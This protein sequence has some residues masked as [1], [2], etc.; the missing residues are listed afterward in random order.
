LEAP[1]AL[2]AAKMR[3]FFDSVGLSFRLLFSKGNSSKTY[4]EQINQLA[5]DQYGHL[6][7]IT[8]PQHIPPQQSK[9]A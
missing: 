9:I 4:I 2:A 8:P 5:R 3:G 6:D 1:L 7:V